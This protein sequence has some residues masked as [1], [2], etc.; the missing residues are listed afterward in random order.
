MDARHRIVVALAF[1][2]AAS[3]CKQSETPPPPR[4]A[5]TA[6]AAATARVVPP[7][8]AAATA[9]PFRVLSVELANAIGADKK[10]AQES[11]KFAPSDTIYASISSEGSAP[12][13]ALKARWTYEDG[14]VVNE[15]TQSI[16][17]NG[18][19]VTEF[20]ISKPGGWPAGKYKLEVSTDGN[21]I[22]TKEFSV[23]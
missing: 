15:S 13:V 9:V 6:Q 2:V 8:A 19:T 1:I 12:S 4:A 10:V 3:A 22:S 21:V 18:P 14:Q 11:E 7:V 5:A 23:Q 17:P 20:H 16:A